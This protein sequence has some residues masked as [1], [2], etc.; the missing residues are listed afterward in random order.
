[1]SSKILDLVAS[2]NPAATAE[3]EAEAEAKNAAAGY[4]TRY[5]VAWAVGALVVI[6]ILVIIWHYWKR[7]GWFAGKS[8]FAVPDADTMNSFV[9]NYALVNVLKARG[10]DTTQLK[11]SIDMLLASISAQTDMKATMELLAAV[12]DEYRKVPMDMM[13]KVYKDTNV[14]PDMTYYSLLKVVLPSIV[15]SEFSPNDIANVPTDLLY[16]SSGKLLI[17]LG[18]FSNYMY[19]VLNN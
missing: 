8:A 16:K 7:G 13:R 4:A 10:Y 12:L 15:T 18:N 9:G 3:A 6:I 11:K 14:T 1:M 19:A 2:T 5:V 17:S